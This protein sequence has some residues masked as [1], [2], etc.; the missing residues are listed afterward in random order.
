MAGWVGNIDEATVG[1]ETFRTVLF[2]GAHAQLTV[3][4]LEPGEEIGWEAH[5]HLDQFLRVEQGQGRVELG[6]TQDCVDE[7]HELHDDWAVVVPAGSWHNVV[8]TGTGQLKLY[9]LYAPP[10]HPPGTVHAT[11][12]KAD[13]AE[14]AEA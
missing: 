11:K 3:M 6:P 12:A 5:P 4:N 9:S 10:E 2:T 14:H 8:N 7:K 1:N 13:A